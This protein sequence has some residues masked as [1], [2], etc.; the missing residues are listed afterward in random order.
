MAVVESKRER[1][2]GFLVVR[3]DRQLSFVIRHRTHMGNTGAAG[4]YDLLAGV[5]LC[6]CCDLHKKGRETWEG[7]RGFFLSYFHALFVLRFASICVR[8]GSFILCKP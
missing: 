3:L 6:T 2:G 5:A 8:I 4:A 1:D 7:H